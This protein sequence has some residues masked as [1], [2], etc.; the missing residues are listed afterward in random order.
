MKLKLGILMISVFLYSCNTNTKKNPCEGIK[1]CRIYT[2][3]IMEYPM[4]Y[5]VNIDSLAQSYTIEI[6]NDDFENT[7]GKLNG[8]SILIIFIDGNG[9]YLFDA[10]NQKSLPNEY[11]PKT[12]EETDYI[13]LRSFN[14][15][16]VG[17]YNNNK[18]SAYSISNTLYFIDPKSKEVLKIVNID[19][20]KPENE[21]SYTGRAPENRYSAP[22]VKDIINS[23]TNSLN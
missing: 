14:K 9:N 20:G 21:I 4:V 1:N 19:G 11:Q 3:G 7:N 13:V 8:K 15:Q 18:T 2:R 10:S 22:S 16:Y 17:T 12:F 5:D 6:I 23:I